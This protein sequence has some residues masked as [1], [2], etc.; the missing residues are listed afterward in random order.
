MNGINLVE[1]ANSSYVTLCVNHFPSGKVGIVMCFGENHYYPFGGSLIEMSALRRELVQTLRG[2]GF[3][4]KSNYVEINE[5][6][7]DVY[8]NALDIQPVEH[9]HF[10][11][12]NKYLS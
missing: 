2:M 7:R 4:V 5:A 9:E 12:E 1:M 6:V 11:Y 3:L 10:M 8:G